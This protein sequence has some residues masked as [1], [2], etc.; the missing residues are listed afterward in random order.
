[1]IVIYLHVVKRFSNLVKSIKYS[2]VV[3]TDFFLTKF[4][5]R[6]IQMDRRKMNKNELGEWDD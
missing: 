4:S 2:H 5:I 3:G 1:L 6:L